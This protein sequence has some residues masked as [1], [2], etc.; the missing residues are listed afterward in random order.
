[1]ANP[2]RRS[3]WFSIRLFESRF[4]TKIKTPL[5]GFQSNYRHRPAFL[6]GV[7]SAILDLTMT[8]SW[9]REAHSQTASTRIRKM[10]KKQKEQNRNL[11][12]VP[13]GPSNNTYVSYVR[14]QKSRRMKTLGSPAFI[15]FTCACHSQAQPSSPWRWI[16]NWCSA[17]VTK[18]YMLQMQSLTIQQGYDIG[19]KRF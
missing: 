7:L 2:W 16:V 5:I 19:N 4:F 13:H 11:N 14:R 10:T 17:V 8:S 9:S 3:A 18:E 15:C 12:S 6:F 1:M